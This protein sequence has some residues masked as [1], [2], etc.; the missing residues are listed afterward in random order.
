MTSHVSKRGVSSFQLKNSTT[1]WQHEVI[2]S[3]AQLRSIPTFELMTWASTS[4]ADPST[5]SSHR[6]VSS[7]AHVL[8]CSLFL[9]ICPLLQQVDATEVGRWL[10]AVPALLPVL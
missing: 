4:A 1:A 9:H 2:N 7:M 8:L 3:C 10:P 5:G 6:V